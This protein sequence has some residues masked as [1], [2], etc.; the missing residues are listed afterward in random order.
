MRFI[1]KSLAA[2]FV[3]PRNFPWP[4]VSACWGACS[5]RQASPVDSPTFSYPMP[6]NLI[7]LIQHPIIY[8]LHGSFVLT[9]YHALT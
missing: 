8:F 3:V 9:V 5:V 4:C 1:A 7:Y 2:M 6:Y